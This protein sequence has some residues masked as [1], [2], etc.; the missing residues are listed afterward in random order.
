MYLSMYCITHT[1]AIL[2][3]KASWFRSAAYHRLPSYTFVNV[4]K[5]SGDCFQ[6]K[7]CAKKELYNIFKYLS[8]LAGSTI[9]F[10]F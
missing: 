3:E 10:N 7:K 2:P 6:T 9:A 8:F 1:N 4:G 5:I